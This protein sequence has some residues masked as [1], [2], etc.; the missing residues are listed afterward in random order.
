MS[1]PTLMPPLCASL[2]RDQNANLMVLQQRER[3]CDRCSRGLVFMRCRQ[4]K[5]AAQDCLTC[6]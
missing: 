2:L 6:A 1:E 3:G 5:G 4:C